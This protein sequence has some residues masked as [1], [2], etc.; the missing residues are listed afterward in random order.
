LSDDDGFGPVQRGG[1]YSPRG[2]DVNPK[3]R[4]S[5]GRDAY[6]R[7]GAAEEPDDTGP[8]FG[9]PSK[10]RAKRVR[11]PRFRK[12]LK[13]LLILL[14]V[15]V[16]AFVIMGV[17][18]ALSA[19][20]KITRVEVDGLRPAVG[21]RNIL[22]VGSDNRDE[23]TRRQR[24]RL[25]TFGDSEGSRTD[26]ILLLSVQGSNA[27]MLSFPRDLWVQRC[28]G[29]SG[30]INAAY[31]IGGA[32]CLV[33]TV[34]ELSDIPV[35]HYMEVNFLGF[36]DIVNAVGGVRICLD[37]PIKDADA[38]IDLPKGCQRLNGR[39]SLGFVRVRKID[40]DLGRIGRQQQFIKALARKVAR[41]STVLN[42]PRLF[43]TGNAVGSA[44]TA[45]KQLGVLD[46]V[47]LGRAGTA[48]ASNDV[49]TF[50]VPGTPTFI[51]GAAV[52]DVD[53]QEASR[54]F[55]SFRDGSV[56]RQSPA[57]VRPED[58]ELEVRNGAGVPG[59]ASEVA[60][61]M[62]ERGFTVTEVG[63]ADPT[64]RTIVQ[65]T[66]GNRAKALVVA[67]QAP[68]GEV[69]IREVSGGPDVALILGRDARGFADQ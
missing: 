41:P 30:R 29:T 67:R 24:R 37:R 51:G 9:P 32:S 52:L 60:R 1:G 14:L 69:D 61:A 4:P 64:N 18:A 48:M 62:S 42:P 7:Y 22:L 58:I 6:Q 36:N 45:N 57:D 56:L 13:W 46:L 3:P 2:I 15:V 28:D 44:L 20:S 40:N 31:G 35:T 47:A 26:T 38:H 53:E 50:A 68:G 21:Q 12:V 63:N 27:A 17:A 5:S 34:S 33:R 23:L 43:E 19:N 54:L 39:E 66:A 55:R 65:Y 8:G 10:G 11:L 25:N 49:P 59:L 16:L